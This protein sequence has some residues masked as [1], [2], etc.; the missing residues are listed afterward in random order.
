MSV[1]DWGVIV[2]A[3]LILWFLLAAFVIQVVALGSKHDRRRAVALA[4]H[5]A[6]LQ[7]DED[8]RR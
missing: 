1:S 3:G 8:D 5:R 4:A 6:R 7:R 2:C